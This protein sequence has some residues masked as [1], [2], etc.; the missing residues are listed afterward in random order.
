MLEHG[1][2]VLLDQ[3]CQKIWHLQKDSKQELMARHLNHFLKQSTVQCIIWLK[4]NKK[5]SELLKRMKC[6]V[7]SDFAGVWET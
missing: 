5:T 1:Q 2:G 6:P 7:L 4:K 3:N